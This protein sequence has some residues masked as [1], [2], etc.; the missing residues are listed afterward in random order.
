MTRRIPNRCYLCGA[1]AIDEWFCVG[2]Q[3]A[4][5]PSAASAKPPTES[6]NGSLGRFHAYWVERFTPEQ[7]VELASYLE[8]LGVG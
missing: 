1:P 4:S 5:P 6:E 2:H 8:P 7:V 3:W